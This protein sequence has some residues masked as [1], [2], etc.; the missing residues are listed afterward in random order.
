MVLGLFLLVV[1]FLATICFLL[2]QHYAYWRRRGVREL[3]PHW[4]L[5]NLA[6]L[7]SMRDS[8]AD[9]MGQLY[10]HPDA[11]NQPFVGIHV[12]HRPA[13]LLRDPDLIK[14]ILIKDFGKFS[15]R[16]S[17][18]DYKGDPLGSQNIFFLKN[19]AWKEVRFKLSP[20]FTS[21][22]LKSMFPLIVEVGSNLDAY[23]REQPLHNERTRCFDLE[24]KELCALFTTDVIASVAYGVQA[25]SFTQPN[26]EFRRHGRAVFEFS[27]KRAAEF[28]LVF[29]LPHLVPLFGFKVV[30]SEATRFLRNT[31]NYVMAERERSQQTRND[32]IDILIEFRRSTQQARAAGDHGQFVFE[33]DI[34]VAQAVL[35]F[36]AGF[37]SSSSTMAFAMY[38]LAKDADIQLRVRHEIKEALIASGGQ[39]TLQLIDSLEYMQMVLLEVLRMYPP[40]PFLDRE[41][42]AEDEDYSLTPYHGFRVPKGMPIYIPCYALHMDPQYFPQPRK[43][44]PE[45]F[46]PTNRKLQTPYTYMPFGLGPHGCIGERFGL[47]QAKVGLVNLMRN[48]QV[49]TSERTPRRMKLDPKAIIL[50]AQGGIHLRLVRDPLGI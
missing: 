1:I 47:L 26:G 7:L 38:E 41:C 29:F 36:T 20:F 35:F 23:L 24:A 14:R 13:L 5:G 27:L 6:G 12:F 17:N 34:L 40:L 16:Y 2:Q 46:S 49:T 4:I 22:K 42:T 3:R 45:R 30:P 10:N 33:G 21:N 50:Q 15:N 19:P 32:L 43:F 48:H 44:Q 37:E 31:I 28:T 8:P 39:V 25:N 9:F 18:S 11:L